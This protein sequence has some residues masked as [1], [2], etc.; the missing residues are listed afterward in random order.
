MRFCF[1]GSLQVHSGCVPGKH[2]TDYSG[3]LFANA[4]DLLLVGTPNLQNS[5]R[6]FPETISIFLAISREF[7]LETHDPII[8][9]GSSAWKVIGAF[10]K[11]FL[12]WHII[13][14]S[15]TYRDSVFASK[16]IRKK[17]CSIL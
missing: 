3:S 14:G 15:E 16:S 9:L 2:R 17:Y 7:S 11:K 10:E 12:A 5:H 1:Y 8:R 4:F 6:L 13:F